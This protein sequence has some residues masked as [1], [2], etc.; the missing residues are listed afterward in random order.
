[1]TIVSELVS[2]LI[3]S[4]VAPEVAASVVAEAFAAGVSTGLPRNSAHE[5]RKAYDRERKRS[6]RNSTGI[7]PESTGH[8]DK[9]LTLKK[10]IKRVRA[11]KHPC[12]PDWKP[13]DAHYEAAAKLHIPRSAVDAKAEDLRIWA[14]STGALKVDWDLTFH[15]FLRRDAPKMAQAPPA[16]TAPTIT[17]ANPSWN[18]WKAH[19]RDL[20]QNNRAALMDKCAVD[21]KPFTV[22]TEWPQQGRT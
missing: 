4:G 14:G 15:G 2:R 8:A 3:V 18:A 7:P 10:D 5:N 22:P 12:P 20:G 13:K 16:A 1:M 19:F 17:P 9:A 11:T 6:Q 21:G